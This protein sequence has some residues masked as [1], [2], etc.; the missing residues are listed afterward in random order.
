MEK[1]QLTSHVNEEASADCEESPAN[2]AN[3][4]DASPCITIIEQIEHIGRSPEILDEGQQR[5]DVV[6]E[7]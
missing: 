1:R 2:I 7:E 3:N 4:R 6:E 5:I